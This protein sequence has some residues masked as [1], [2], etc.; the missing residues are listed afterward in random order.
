MD[1]TSYF[2]WLGEQTLSGVRYSWLVAL[3]ISA[4]FCAAAIV[5]NPY[6]KKPVDSRTIVLWAPILLPVAILA[7]GD[8]FRHDYTQNQA[9][10]S[11]WPQYAVIG[12]FLAHLPITGYFLYSLRGFRWFATTV[13]LVQ[14]Y[15]SYWAAFVASMSVTGDW[16]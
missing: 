1:T 14:I 6:K 5:N 2:L 10:P 13:S 16:L 9:K 4:A 11:E 8:I 7:V 3:A 12:L 15:L